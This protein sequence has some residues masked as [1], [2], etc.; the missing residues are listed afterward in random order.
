VSL[1]GKSILLDCRWLGL[2]GAGRATE[3]LLRGLREL[4]PPG[5]WTLW[6]PEP[7]GALAWDG[8]AH[9]RSNGTPKSWAG[10]RALRLPE[11]DVAVYLHQIRPLRPG[12]SVTLIHDTIPL[13][14]GSN[15]LV[16]RLYLR[17]VARLSTRI[18]TVSEHSRRSIEDDLA[19]PPETI[20]VVTYPVDAEQAVR[21]RRL[22]E[23]LPAQDT[24]LYV[25]SFSPHK[26][27][28]RLIHAFAETRFRAEGGKLRL[29]GGD[30]RELPTT[31]AG[32]EVEG[33]CSQERLEQLYAT[34]RLLVQPSLEEGF[35]L[36]AWEAMCCGLSVC[37]SDS[38]SLP[39]VTKGLVRTFSPTSIAELTAAIDAVAEEGADVSAEVAAGTPTLAEF[40]QRFVDEAAAAAG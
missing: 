34:S 33:P 30:A 17:A 19:V 38:G 37:A 13:R 1:E 2:G 4:R 7:V 16:K 20:S 8:A 36:P 14:H 40:A 12:R 10:Q 24:A 22:R 27:L 35:G 6:G 39:E 18:L 9:E 25:G 11:H 15:R 32:V 26:N 5:R 29:V 23:E 28:G 31:L 21:V 3:L